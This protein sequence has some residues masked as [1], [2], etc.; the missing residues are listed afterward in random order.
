[1][2]LFEKNYDFPNITNYQYIYPISEADVQNE[3]LYF[4]FCFGFFVSNSVSDEKKLKI[5]KILLKK[6]YSASYFSTQL[7]SSLSSTL[8][9]TP[10]VNLKYLFIY[11]FTVI[12][13][14]FQLLGEIVPHIVNL[15]FPEPN[16]SIPENRLIKLKIIHFFDDFLAKFLQ[17]NPKIE[18]QF[19]FI[20]N[21]YF[22]EIYYSLIYRLLSMSKKIQISIYLEITRDVT[23]NFYVEHQLT[24]IFNTE[25]VIITKNFLT[26]DL[27]ISDTL[28]LPQKHKQ[29]FILSSLKDYYQ[30]AELTHIIQK[31]VVK[32]LFSEETA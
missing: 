21:L 2:N 23:G 17:K 9:I 29:I 8:G 3:N 16:Y 11:Y 32:K 5:G 4:S 19:L 24:D 22:S 27:I 12:Y 1:M 18:K 20:K 26:A 6:H 13:V 31:M 30:W 28:E 15:Y 7:L 25:T 10:P 14:H